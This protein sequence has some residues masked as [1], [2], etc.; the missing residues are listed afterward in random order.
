[1]SSPIQ[2]TQKMLGNLVPLD[3]LPQR[4][5]L[6]LLEKA[7][8]EL[9]PRGRV[10]WP[11]SMPAHDSVF[12]LSG[13]LAKVGQ[14]GGVQLIRAG[15]EAAR[16]AVDPHN[17]RQFTVIARED[18]QIL[19]LDSEQLDILV[20]W[21]HTPGASVVDFLDN[22]RTTDRAWLEPI[23]EHPVFCRVSPGNLRA[24]MDSLERVDVQAGQRVIREGDL[25]D[26]CYFLRSGRARVTRSTTPD[27]EEALL[28]ELDPGACFGEEALLTESVRNASVTMLE[29]GQLMRMEK[30]DFL[31]LLREPAVER[32]G[33]LSARRKIGQGAL[34]L[35]VR[36]PA[37][38]ARVH[39]RGA[40]SMPLSLLR[41]KAWL[42]DREREY[43]TYCDT[44]RRGVAACYLLSDMGYRVVTLRDGINGLDTATC[45]REM[46]NDID[47]VLHRDGTVTEHPLRP[48]Y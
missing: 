38:Y 11:S 12:L 25:G 26:C 18:A 24:I 36:T 2:V 23:F 10:L 4:H 40:P 33:Y 13:L 21:S 16:Y 9:V 48:I 7:R 3:V 27:G 46:V 6:R 35:D 1:M 44:G 47:F 28:A 32:V 14:D 20:S 45:R 37:E 39:L 34:W 22:V 42:L 29:D 31:Q 43:V 41:M 17:P 19:R 8:T 15:S 5:L 30:Q